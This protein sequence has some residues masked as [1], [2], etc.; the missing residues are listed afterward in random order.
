MTSSKLNRR[1]GAILLIV[2]VLLALFA[3]IGLTFVLYS[4]SEAVN[5][6]IHREAMVDPG[7]K[8][9]DTA[10]I[11][12]FYSQLLYPVPDSG[13]GITSALRGHEMARMVYGY[14]PNASAALPN[15]QANP[16]YVSANRVFNVGPYGG[17]GMFGETIVTAAGNIDRRNII[18]FSVTSNTDSLIDPENANGTGVRTGARAYPDPALPAAQIQY[19]PIGQ[20]IPKN[21]PYTYPDRNNAYLAMMDPASGRIVIP[22]YHRPGLFGA[23]GLATSNPNWTNAAG[24]YTILRPRPY[25]HRIDTG[26]GR[27]TVSDFPYPPA[28]PDGTYT[29]DVQNY[30]WGNGTQQNDSVWLYANLPPVKW[31]GRTLQPMVAPLIIPLDGR[32]NLGVASNLNSGSHTSQNGFGAY[33]INF[34]K[35]AP[36]STVFS[37]ATDTRSIVTYRN[38]GQTKP[39]SAAKQSAANTTATNQYFINPM[40]GGSPEVMNDWSVVNWDAIS[41][42]LIPNPP[43]NNFRTDPFFPTTGWDN[44]MTGGTNRHHSL[45]NPYFETEVGTAGVGGRTLKLLDFRQTGYRYSGK[46]STYAPPL[47]GLTTTANSFTGSA[48]NHP[49][50]LVRAL[51]TPISNALNYAGASSLYSAGATNISLNG[52]TAFNPMSPVSTPATFNPAAAPGGDSVPN[53]GYRSALAALGP[54]NLNR[55]LTEYRVNPNLPL[56]H[57]TNVTAMPVQSFQA[58]RDRQIFA[59]DIFE[60]LI[61]ATGAP[62]EGLNVNTSRL[63]PFTAVTTGN[64]TTM[65]ILRYLAQISVNIVDQIDND[66]I[67]TAFVWNPANTVSPTPETDPANFLPG[68]MANNTVIG[69]EKTRLVLNEVYSEVTNDPNDPSLPLQ[70]ASNDFHVRFFIEVLNPLN[71][72]NARSSLPA[73]SADAQSPIGGGKA[74][75]SISGNEAYRIQ[76]YTDGAPV[77]NDLYG[78]GAATNVTGSITSAAPRLTVMP[79]GASAVEPNAN[80]AT[81]TGFRNFCP[82]EAVGSTDPMVYAPPASGQLIQISPTAKYASNQ[83][84]YTVPKL[85][86]TNAP[87]VTAPDNIA[88]FVTQQLNP[89][90]Q[91]V[92]AVVLQRKMNPYLSPASDNVNPWI[93]VDTMQDIY[94]ND[95]VR[96]GEILPRPNPLPPLP[97]TR[98]A[99]TPDPNANQTKSHSRRAPMYGFRGQTAAASF[100]VDSQRSFLNHNT[101]NPAAPLLQP[102]E[103][104]T[105]LDRRLINNSELLS[106]SGVKPHEQLHYFVT[107]A[108]GQTL[109]NSA[110]LQPTDKQKQ[111]TPWL[112]PQSNLY[113]ALGTMDVKP[114]MYGIPTGGRQPGKVNVNAMWHPDV[115][116]AV[117]DAN[118]GNA[119][120]SGDQSTFWSTTVANGSASRS[121]NFP[122]VNDTVDDIPASATADRPFKSLAGSTTLQDS[123]L[124]PDPTAGPPNNNTPVVLLPNRTDLPH[125]YLKEEMLRKMTNNVGTTSD[126]YLVLFTISYFEIRS[127]ANPSVGRYLPYLGRE[128]FAEIPGDLRVQYSSIIDRSMIA[129]LPPVR[130][131][132]ANEPP[133]VFDANLPTPTTSPSNFFMTE[134]VN[135]LDPLANRTAESRIAIRCQGGNAN[136]LRIDYEGRT[137]NL[138]HLNYPSA[139]LQANDVQTIVIGHGSEAKVYPILQNT[140]P[141]GVTFIGPAND[142]IGYIVIPANGIPGNTANGAKVGF[143]VHDYPAGSMVSNIIPGN[144]GPQPSF[145]VNTPAARLI[146]RD[147]QK[148][149]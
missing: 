51:T 105:H 138:R 108:N 94:V 42:N 135:S 68:S 110:A 7:D 103:W 91:G 127:P 121:R 147:L 16:N 85:R 12:A 65:S 129:T 125:H 112:S 39:W 45:Y 116:A 122:N 117:L 52:A 78:A 89:N 30:R 97:G 142:G 49:S 115:L 104:M 139:S 31:R 24:R 90:N 132:I 146:I 92:H 1:D 88:N 82:R 64:A 37:T 41:P 18:N 59:R 55:T 43:T 136:G 144:P 113:R 83:L 73:A 17:V 38:Q 44:N 143:V 69:V 84:F 118:G 9:D 62:H 119:F 79:E 106:V 148:V 22:S 14:N 134:M 48:P 8:P 15:G 4:Q 35:I 72:T 114:Y 66:D 96:Y 120:N 10:A 21:A 86:P 101:S 57:P 36:T 6:R 53:N 13:P 130:Q 56:S 126:T 70:S 145:D 27:G 60:R 40:P 99:N 111:L 25:D 2:L 141:S 46:T 23:Q 87:P 133:L 81:N 26:D 5:A 20:F 32:V 75:L 71:E 54:V 28:N 107:S 98:P 11:N 93:T 131:G 128:A 109:P 50:N 137:Y 123:L 34:G 95:A 47:Y 80:A 124:R 3:V 33:E 149:K 77:R 58:N 61:L 19:N 100:A 63:L 67:C 76:V 140:G 102:F 29:G 74:D